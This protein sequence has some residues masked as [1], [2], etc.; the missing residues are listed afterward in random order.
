MSYQNLLN[1]YQS[2]Q[3]QFKQPKQLSLMDLKYFRNT[4]FEEDADCETIQSCSGG[5]YSVTDCSTFLPPDMSITV[6]SEEGILSPSTAD[7]NRSCVHFTFPVVAKRSQ[8]LC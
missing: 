8:N 2:V 6:E 7:M 4:R 5:E 1:E 3:T